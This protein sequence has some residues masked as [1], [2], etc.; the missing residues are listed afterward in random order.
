MSIR[1]CPDCN[2]NGNHWVPPHMR[3]SYH[4]IENTHVSATAVY[5]HKEIR[6]EYETCRLCNGSGMVECVAIAARAAGGGE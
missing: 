3:E 6:P 2:G 5:M 4:V 1:K